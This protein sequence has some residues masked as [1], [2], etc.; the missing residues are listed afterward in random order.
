M[1]KPAN[2]FPV[3]CRSHLTAEY[4]MTVFGDDYDTKDGTCIRDIIH[5]NDLIDGHISALQ[6]CL[7]ETTGYQAVNLGCG[8]GWSVLEIIKEFEKELGASI[9]YK[10]GPRR[11][12]DTISSY[13]STAYAKQYLGWE[14][15]QD[16]SSICR[17]TIRYMRTSKAS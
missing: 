5:I 3:M 10:I 17:D 7:N 1:D 13:A 4:T 6:K 2:L 9:N 8:T 14:T 11:P 12:G 15:K 16:L